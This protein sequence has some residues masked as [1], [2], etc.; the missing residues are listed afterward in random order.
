[1]SESTTGHP[2]GDELR[3]GRRFGA[4][5]IGIF[6]AVLVAAVLFGVLLL[7]VRSQSAFVQR[8]DFHLAHRMHDY[9]VSHP[10][11]T[12]VMKVIS[13]LGS[14]VAWIIYL[15]PVFCWLLFRRLWRLAVFVA[16]TGIGSSVLNGLI[17]SF[18][19]RARPALQDPVAHAAGLSFPS[20]HSQAAFV[21]CSILL[22]V[23]LPII[24]RRWRRL[25]WAL[26]ITFVL[27]VGFSRI[28]LGV[29]YLFDVIGA[30]LVGAVW[31]A[32]MIAIFRAWRQELGKP[33][34]PASEGLEPE[35]AP[36]LRP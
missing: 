29:H 31:V 5:A 2:D 13:D 11:F 23:F 12:H 15:V 24:P 16:V 17:K 20:G 4:R 8:I 28:A 1:V 6:I 22:A 9:A 7:L 21:G 34:P 36:R 26:A 3:A 33:T 19:G 14:S 32:G 35:D 30:Y 25:A 27:L 18:V 10:T